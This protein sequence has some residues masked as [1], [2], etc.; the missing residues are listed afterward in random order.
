MMIEQANAICADL[1]R[2]ECCHLLAPEFDRPTA[3]IPTD[4]RDYF[5]IGELRQFVKDQEFPNAE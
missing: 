2:V 5:E 1:T 4:W 3:A